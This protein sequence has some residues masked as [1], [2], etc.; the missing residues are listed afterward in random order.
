LG[1][2]AETYENPRVAIEE[3]DSGV[4][5]VEVPKESVDSFF[6]SGAV[7]AEPSRELPPN[8]CVILKADTNG[9]TAPGRSDPGKRAIVPLRVP[10]DGVMGIRPK[11]KEQAFALDLLLDDTIRLVTLIGKAG[12][13]KTLMA[14]AAGLRKVV[15]DGTFTR[16]LVS[17]P[18]M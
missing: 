3:L 12:T 11:N 17:R 13:G 14:L 18:V 9:H 4:K 1:I 7:E 6:Q 5:E 15:E 10:R 8:V 2:E 16:M